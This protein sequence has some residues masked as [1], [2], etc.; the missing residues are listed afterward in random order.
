MFRTTDEVRGG[1]KQAPASL[2]MFFHHP[3]SSLMGPQPCLM[4]DE[5]GLEATLEGHG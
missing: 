5:I 3:L 1:V 4:V 2:P